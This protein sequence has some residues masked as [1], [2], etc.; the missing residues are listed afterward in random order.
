MLPGSIAFDSLSFSS[1]RYKFVFC[2]NESHR[3]NR[4]GFVSNFF[5]ALEKKMIRG[6]G[7]ED[8]DEVSR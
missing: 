7:D 2:I 4:N 5:S 3:A 8:E 1:R 6:D